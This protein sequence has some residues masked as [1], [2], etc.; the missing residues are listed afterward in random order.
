MGAGSSPAGSAPAG[1]DPPV[2]AG[3]PRNVRY[4]R[5]IRLDGASGDYPTDD[6]GRYL[7]VHPVT[8]RVVLKLLVKLGAIP[9]AASTGSKFSAIQRGTAAQREA[10]AK[11]IVR[12]TLK[13]DIAA[14][15]IRLERIVVD[16]SAPGATLTAVYFV[17]L[18]EDPTGS[19]TPQPI[20]ISH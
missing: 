1:S 19:S 17:N 11:Q 13:D 16:A 15:D 6:D 10:Q 20:T 12:D 7:D 4:P 8:A 14:G 5:A 2:S 3:P 18:R 9:S